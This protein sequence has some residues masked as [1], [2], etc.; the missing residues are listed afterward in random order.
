MFR[1]EEVGHKNY[2]VCMNLDVSIK[3]NDY[4]DSVSFSIQ[5]AKLDRCFKPHIIYLDNTAVG[6]VSVYINPP[7]Y[8]VINFFILDKYQGKGYG[9]ESVLSLFVKLK[10]EHGA[11]NISC[12]VHVDHEPALIFWNRMGFTRSQV[13]EDN[14]VF[15]RRML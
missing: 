12:P 1:F 6:F 5:E 2:E 8:E 14:Y 15:M 9:R 10:K 11:R 3:N 7:S 13:I 4:V